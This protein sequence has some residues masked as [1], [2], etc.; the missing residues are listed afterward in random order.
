[1]ISA[2]AQSTPRAR[3]ALARASTTSAAHQTRQYRYG[4]WQVDN[5]DHVRGR[6]RTVR[7][8]YME[9]LSRGLSWDKKS[10]NAAAAAAA[11]SLPYS[12]GMSSNSAAYTDTANVMSWSDDLSGLGA[13]RTISS[14]DRAAVA[15]LLR[16]QKDTPQTIESLRLPRKSVRDYVTKFAPKGSAQAV[17]AERIIEATSQFPGYTDL[18]GYKA[19]S[20]D[21]PN[22]PWELTAEEKSKHYSDLQKYRPIEWNEPDGLPAQAKNTDNKTDSGEYKSSKWNEPNG[23][24]SRTPE[25]QSKDYKDLHKY[26]PVKWNEPNG[27]PTV[28]AEETTKSYKDLGKY[29]VSTFSEPDGLQ[30]PTMEELSKNYQDLDK[31]AQ[32]FKCKDTTLKAQK[33]R[34]MDATPRGTPLPSKPDVQPTNYA[35]EYKDLDKYGPVKWNEPDGLPLPT[36]EESTKEYNDLHRYAQYD[37]AGPNSEPTP[38]GEASKRPKDLAAY[39]RAGFEESGVKEHVHPEELSKNYKDLSGYR[40]RAFDAVDRKHSVSP[41]A[42]TKNYKDLDSYQAILDEEASVAAQNPFTAEFNEHDQEI[43]QRTAAHQ[44]GKRRIINL[45]DAKKKYQTAQ[46][47]VNVEREALRRVENLVDNKSQY[48]AIWGAKEHQQPPVAAQLESVAE[49]RLSNLEDAKAQHESSWNGATH[50]HKQPRK[51]QFEQE[52]DDGLG[53]MDESFPTWDVAQEAQLKTK[54]RSSTTSAATAAATSAIHRTRMARDDPYSKIPQGLEVS[55][56]QETGGKATWP[57]VVRHHHP[58]PSKANKKADPVW[59]PPTQA[60]NKD[61]TTSG[62]GGGDAEYVVLAFDPMTQTVNVAQTRSSGA[63]GMDGNATASSSQSSPPLTPAEVILRLSNPAKF[64]PH[65]QPLQALGYEIVSGRGDVLIFR[66]VSQAAVDEDGSA[67][68]SS[69]YDPRSIGK[70]KRSVGKRVAIG[71]VAATGTA[72]GVGTLAEYMSTHGM[73]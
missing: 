55:Y 65:F 48:A 31:Y 70:K 42:A 19:K 35:D 50:S 11:A 46:P 6:H 53:S 32:G 26:G 28:T 14:M 69:T 23:L 33:V 43:R 54:S 18:N 45:E 34:E 63:V 36:S 21:S 29:G 8:R 25:E 72:Y 61:T 17:D 24:P 68:A 5:N 73:I 3:L 49:E 9:T 15:H 60:I 30:Q 66:R 39:P 57:T 4:P 13:A 38:L 20:F 37:N 51:P 44:S 62:S 16:P 67:P 27:F 59:Q 1:M 58:R 2:A 12:H 64:F 52:E 7:Y 41:E 71:A 47:V 56:S 10:A 40:P 22:T